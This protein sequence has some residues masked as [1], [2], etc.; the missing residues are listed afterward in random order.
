MDIVVYPEGTAEW[1][2]RRF[3]CALGR[4]GVTEDKR[5]GDGATPAGRFPLRSVLYRPDRT[6]PPASVLPVAPLHPL[7]GWCDDTGDKRYNQFI[8]QPYSASFELLWREDHIYDVIVVLGYN[9]DPVVPGRGSAI[10]LH[11]ARPDFTPTQGCIA[12]ARENLLRIIE[13][14]ESSTR[15]C[16]KPR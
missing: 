2:G 5:E 10:F 11:A 1:A 6:G 15:L 9:D 4:A 3:P 13:E 12:F 14:C 16:V 7:D 8:R